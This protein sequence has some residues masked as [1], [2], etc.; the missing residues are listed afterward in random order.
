MVDEAQEAVEMIKAEAEEEAVRIE[1]EAEARGRSEG[2]KRARE[3]L[4]EAESGARRSKIR[5]RSVEEGESREA[6]SR[7]KA[8]ILGDLFR[9]L[10]IGFIDE[11]NR[12]RKTYR[13]LI[14]ATIVDAI[15]RV[16]S[17]GYGLQVPKG[18]RSLYTGRAGILKAVERR[19]AVT[20]SERAQLKTGF[21]LRA[22]DTGATVNFDL[23][24]YL[25]NVREDVLRELSYAIFE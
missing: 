1:Q 24:E 15:K 10:K 16:P 21:A 5:A 3:I 9:K 17:S 2:E 23:Q 11:M 22:E 14:E 6:A 19:D 13:R 20:L 8:E 25:E 7:V 4:S 12:D 18:H